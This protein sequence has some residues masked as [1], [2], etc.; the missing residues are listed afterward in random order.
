MQATRKPFNED[1]CIINKSWKLVV[2]VREEGEAV[3]ILLHGEEIT[4]N[5]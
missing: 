1:R 2:N 5:N 3:L 4:N